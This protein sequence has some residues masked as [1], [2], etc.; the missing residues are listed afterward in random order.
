MIL[1]NFK[2]SEDRT[3]LE[4]ISG[5]RLLQ[6][7][8]TFAATHS[9]QKMY[10]L[11]IIEV[12]HSQLSRNYLF[13][14]LGEY[15]EETGDSTES[16][17]KRFLK[18]LDDLVRS[19]SHDLFSRSIFFDKEV[20]DKYSGEVL[21]PKLKSLSKFSQ[22]AMTR[23]IDFC[24]MTIHDEM[25]EFIIPDPKQY[26]GER[27]GEKNTLLYPNDRIKLNNNGQRKLN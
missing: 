12:N 11:K 3:E 19:D 22:T 23:F 13:T 7:L 1:Q 10:C 5:Q 14:I 26:L 27:Q 6:F 17:E 20:T 4:G 16:V 25:P 18:K 8:E 2:I 15:G 21:E 24:I 9:N